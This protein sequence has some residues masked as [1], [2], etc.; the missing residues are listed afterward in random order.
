MIL[1][2]LLL[3][4]ASLGWLGFWWWWYTCKI[5][6]TCL[7]AQ[8]IVVPK[9]T[10]KAESGIILFNTN[11][12]NALTFAGWG[13][14]RDSL[15]SS[16]K[17]GQYLDIEGEYTANEMNN[18][19]FENLGLARANAIKQ[20]FPD[21]V[22]S[23]LKLSSLLINGRPTMSLGPWEASNLS[24]KDIPKQI[25]EMGNKT[26]IHF[27]Y[28]SDQRLKDKEI[29][30][31]LSE[32]STKYKGTNA[33]FNITGH[34]DSE[35]SDKEN[36]RLGKTRADAIKRYLVNHGIN[37]TNIHTSSKG[38]S[39]PVA[40]NRTPVGRQENRRVELEIIQKQ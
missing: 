18:T 2:K 30:K 27:Q 12:S 28:N 22:Q 20:L 26:I 35:G 5:C 24:I 39:V 37:A 10:L 25:E 17:E 23:D 36:L 15:I 9:D 40:D 16:L 7:C 33:V 4:L 31:Y 29:E 8:P 19:K 34:T 14:Y 11:D 38:E 32:L 1:K 6:T 13:L 3:V 21:S